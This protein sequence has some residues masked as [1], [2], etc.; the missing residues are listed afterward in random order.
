MS[1]IRGNVWT[2]TLDGSNN[3]VT[4]TDP[5]N[6]V[7]SFSYVPYTGAVSEVLW[8]IIDPGGRTTYFGVDGSGQLTT[9]T[10]ANGCETTFGYEPSTSGLLQTITN[11]TG[12]CTTYAFDD[13]DRLTSVT[14]PTGGVSYYSYVSP[15]TVVTD[16]LGN[17]TTFSAGTSDDDADEIIAEVTDPLGNNTYTARPSSRLSGVMDPR[18]SITTYNYLPA[19][20]TAAQQLQS[21]QLPNGGI[22]TYL[23]N[24]NNLVNQIVDPN[25]NLSSINWN[26]VVTLQRDSLVDPYGNVTTYTYNSQSQITAIQDPLGRTT[27]R[28]YDTNGNLSAL[29]DPL[30]NRTTYGYNATTSSSRRPI[31]WATRRTRCAT[32]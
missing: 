19:T 7:T 28:V 9:I 11:P 15:G 4:I 27:T 12:Q 3:P 6:R 21:V 22:F 26:T 23:Y 14:W 20:F 24:S 30:G 16:P 29:V 5:L 2:V 17:V 31:R 25:G 8:S 1:D 10:N 32:T 18:L 13:N